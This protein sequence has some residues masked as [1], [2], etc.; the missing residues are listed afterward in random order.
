MA[1]YEKHSKTALSKIKQVKVIQEI[2]RQKWSKFVYYHPDGNIF[3]T[4][5]IYEVYANTK[6]YK[7]VLLGVISKDKEILGVL[8]SVIQRKY[9]SLIGNSTARS[10]IWGG[11]LIK[12]DDPQILELILR[13]HENKAKKVLYIHNSETYVI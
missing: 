6:K 11:P 3:Q 8:L 13:E 10:I 9:K 7:P 12:N 2:D 5:E 1:K 4:P